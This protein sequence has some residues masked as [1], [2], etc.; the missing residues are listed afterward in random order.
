MLGAGIC[1]YQKPYSGPSSAGYEVRANSGR[2]VCVAPAFHDGDHDFRPASS[3]PKEPSI[4]ASVF[5]DMQKKAYEEFHNAVK[6]GIES[7]GPTPAG[8]AEDLLAKARGGNVPEHHGGAHEA[9]PSDRAGLDNGRPAQPA[10]DDRLPQDAPAGEERRVD[11][12]R[13]ESGR[14]RSPLLSR[15]RTEKQDSDEYK[16][17]KE[18]F[19]KLNRAFGPFTLDGASSH[20]NHLCAEYLTKEH[21]APSLHVGKHRVWLNPPYSRGNP[22]RFMGWALAEVKRGAPVFCCLVPAYTA[23]GWWREHVERE[24]AETIRGPDDIWSSVYEGMRFTW[25][26]F[27]DGIKVGVH[28]LAGR[29]AFAEGDDDK[30]DTARFSSAVVVYRRAER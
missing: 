8:T 14:V 17:P 23:E 15:P 27:E 5:L 30:A 9:G 18:L 13:I 1:G 20:S 16:T 22:D 6:E 4:P 19:E 2:E 12:G 3:L 10:G 11:S 21:D 28:F 25:R 26:E 24:G 29:L 7:E